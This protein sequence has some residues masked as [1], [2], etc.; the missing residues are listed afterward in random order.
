MRKSLLLATVALVMALGAG[1]SYKTPVN[2]VQ[3][4]NVY[5]SYDEKIPGKFAV[6]INADTNL[7]DKTVS[8]SSFTCAAHKFP[9]SLTDSFTSSIIATNESIFESIFQRENIPSVEE[10]KKDNLSGYIFI[11]SK[12]FEPRLQFIPGFWSATASASTDIGFDYNIRDSQNNLVLNG[13]IS[14]NRT[15]DGGAGGACEGGSSVLAESISKS[16][17]DALERYGERVSNSPKL[18]EV[19]K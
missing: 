17:R 11:T 14:G 19:F 7:L 16:L 2:T 12:L 4:V 3:S 18:R 5:S 1:C 9:I 15:A 6:I 8:P 10:M 13:S